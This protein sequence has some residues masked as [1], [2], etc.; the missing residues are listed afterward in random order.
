MKISIVGAG[1]VGLTAGA[2]F[3][4]R[5][6][7]VICV[8]VDRARVD[9]VNAG[10]SP[11]HEPG[12]GRLLR[13]HAG[14]RLRAT[15]RI[16][17]AVGATSVTFVAVGTPV[18]GG[19]I[20][21]SYL[22]RAAR[23]IGGAL[24]V[25]DR[26]HVVAVKSTVPPGTT[27]GAVR[28]ILEESSG[29]RVGEDFG[30]AT[31]P[32]FLTEGTAVD[33]FMEPDRIVI[34]GSDDRAR[35]VVERLYESFPPVPR[36]RTSNATAEMIKYTSNALLSALISFSNEMA[37]LCDALGGVDVTDVTDAVH[38]SRYLTVRHDG[39]REVVAPIASFLEAGCG[40]GGSCLPKDLEALIESG[41][42]HGVAM[43]VLEAVRDVNRGQPGRLLELIRRHHEDLRGVRTTVLGLAYKPDTG[44]V[45]ESP[46]F[47]VIHDLLAAGA[48]VT[49][50]DP[51]A[52]PEARRVLPP[53]RVVYAEDL[54][55]AVRDAEV[56]A[57]VTRW[58][59]FETLHELLRDRR[60][61][62]LVVDGRRVLDP[63]RF[64]RYEG[65]GRST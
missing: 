45:R 46:A 57:L 29:K 2:C 61:P 62:P 43:R 53:E 42:S 4:E 37:R 56:V 14:E 36:F 22:R 39:D 13:R 24:A 58:P 1:Y 55:R 47:P 20:D 41:R 60:P 33:D 16:G 44:D 12:L 23:E 10:R 21:L 15:E 3:A 18:A 52:M 17:E 50:F 32:E 7:E 9:A 28:A 54:E 5:G 30:L 59:Q 6:H 8:D 34:G 63:S 25:A 31:N 64:A 35:D 40:F 48:S 11:I 27:D 65:I 49:V 51:A 38:A 26:Y 19:T